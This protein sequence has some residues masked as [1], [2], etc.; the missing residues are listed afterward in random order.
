M[1]KRVYNQC[2]QA[3]DASKVF[4][5]T[6]DNRIKEY[7]EQEGI[8]VLMTS[9]ICLTGTDR[10]AEAA[11]IL[12]GDVF[13]NVQ[14]DE[15][16]FNIKDIKLLMDV[17]A[18]DP[19]KIYCGFAEIIDEVTYRSLSTPKMVFSVYNKL[20]YTSRNPM[21]GNKTGVFSGAKRQICAYSFPKAALDSYAA[22]ASKTPLEELE[23]LEL[24]RFL[25]LG[26]DVYGIEMSDIS[27]PVDHPE[28]VLKVENFLKNA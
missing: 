5:A 6:D 8:Q 13:I 26:I 19:S 2:I 18:T 9:E 25:E 28:D 21:P 24:L 15:P 27:I 17:V 10:V 3:F 16:I 1:I 14:G 23:D 22:R 12:G 11:Q 20:M 7:C 4:V